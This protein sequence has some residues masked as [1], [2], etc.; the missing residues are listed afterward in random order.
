VGYA[1]VWPAVA[2]ADPPDSNCTS[3]SQRAISQTVKHVAVEV[4][5]HFVPLTPFIGSLVPSVIVRTVSVVT[6]E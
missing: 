6:V 5:Y 2:T 4:Q 1:Y 3:S